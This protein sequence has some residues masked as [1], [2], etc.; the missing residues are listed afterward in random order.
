MNEVMAGRR[1][2]RLAW[3]AATL[4]IALAIGVL[5]LSPSTGVPHGIWGLDKIAHAS[6]FLVLVLPTAALWPR[7]SAKVG[8]LA[9]V[10]GGAIELIQPFAG[11]SAELGDLVAD[12]IGVG[13]G[14][15]VG[16]S[17]RRAVV[18]PLAARLVVRSRQGG[19]GSD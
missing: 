1:Q 13:L 14:I 4:A 12:G 19:N 15:I 10:Y 11:R 8:A 9:V 3:G 2:I 18:L 17:L 7:I 16:S 6:A 5:T